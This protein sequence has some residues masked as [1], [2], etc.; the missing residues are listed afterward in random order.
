MSIFLYDLCD[1]YLSICDLFLQVEL[2]SY[3]LHIHLRNKKMTQA[4]EHE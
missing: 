3:T 1:S 4:E 2:K